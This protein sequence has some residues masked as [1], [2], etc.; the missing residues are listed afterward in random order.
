VAALRRAYPQARPLEIGGIISGL[1]WR[2]AALEQARKKHA[3][4]G[5]PVYSYWLTYAAPHFD[6]QLGCSHCQDIPFAFD[7]VAL[8]DQRTGNTPEARRLAALVAQAFV[9]FAATGDPS[10]PGLAWPRFEPD[11]VPTMVF[12][13]VARVEHDPAGEA[14]R[15]M[16]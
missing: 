3:Q 4:G 12:D 10:Q 5:A 9:N 16:A 6:G 11:S 13:R 15:L 14:R 1:P 2:N 7:N 8:A